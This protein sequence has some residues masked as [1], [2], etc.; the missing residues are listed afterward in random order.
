M[1]EPSMGKGATE[2]TTAPP[3]LRRLGLIGALAVSLEKEERPH[4]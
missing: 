3:N 4:T 2:Y 1:V